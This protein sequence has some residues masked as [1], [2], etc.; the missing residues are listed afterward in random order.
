MSINAKI[1]IPVPLYQHFLACEKDLKELKKAK[2]D[3][4]NEAKK[5]APLSTSDSDGFEEDSSDVLKKAGAGGSL[6]LDEPGIVIAP[7]EVRPRSPTLPSTAVEPTNVL[8]RIPKRHVASAKEFMKKLQEIDE[9]KFAFTKSGE[10]ILDGKS[11]D[12][13]LA[14]A[15]PFLLYKKRSSKTAPKNF[16][17]FE[18]FLKGLD[19]LP[20]KTI[21]KKRVMR[22][23]DEWYFLGN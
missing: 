23:M 17:R 13:N 14:D 18:S 16:S 12:L 5:G 7:V 19:V 3:S 21:P 11:V 9:R 4:G 6:N 10:V 15:L 8:K 1:L 22:T 2:K 20:H